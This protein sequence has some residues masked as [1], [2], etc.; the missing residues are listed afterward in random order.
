MANKAYTYY[1]ELPAWAKGVV[2]VGGLAVTYIFVS[3]IISRIKKQ[4]SDKENRQAVESAKDDLQDL[5]KRGVK[6]TLTKAQTDS[7]ADAI[8]NQ[9]KNADLL[10]QSY[11]VTERQFNKLKNDADYLML[12]TSW[13][14]RTYPDAFFGNVSN[15]TLEAAIQNELFN[16]S[17]SKLNT[18]LSK[19]GI[20][21]TI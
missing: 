13:G 12:K 2:V 17:I 14:V 7:M 21:Y 3:Q 5:N 9:Y 4:A 16:S 10:L 15:V 18:I 19:K 20:N 8:L 11:T 6:P 1:T